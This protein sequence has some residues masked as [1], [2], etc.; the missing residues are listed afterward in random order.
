MCFS[1]RLYL[2]FY[3]GWTTV[4]YFSHVYYETILINLDRMWTWTC[5]CWTRYHSMISWDWGG[6][7]V[8]PL[9]PIL[10]MF[11]IRF[12]P[13]ALNMGGLGGGGGSYYAKKGWNETEK[14]AGFYY[15]TRLAI[16]ATVLP[17]RLLLHHTW[18]PLVKIHMRP[19]TTLILSR[20]FRSWHW[21]SGEKRDFVQFEPH[22][23]RI[24]KKT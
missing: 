18:D 19:S 9:D 20:F 22:A 23:L 17:C 2:F 4:L 7:C 6:S 3:P 1:L 16:S 24:N 10:F 8:T 11:F 13:L 5:D 14:T 15:S 12:L 21:R